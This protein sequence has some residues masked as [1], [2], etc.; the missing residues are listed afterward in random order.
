MVEHVARSEEVRNAYRILVGIF[1]ES[2]CWGAREED[3][4]IALRL[5]LGN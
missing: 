3:G 4:K 5:V 1:S 2:V